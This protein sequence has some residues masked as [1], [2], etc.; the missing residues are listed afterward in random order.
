[1]ERLP[2]LL[3]AVAAFLVGTWAG[4]LFEDPVIGAIGGVAGLLSGAAAFGLQ[5][6]W[7]RR[8]WPRLAPVRSR[9]SRVWDEVSDIRTELRTAFKAGSVDRG[10]WE[11]RVREFDL[12]FWAQLR[13]IEPDDARRLQ[14]VEIAF[15]DENTNGGQ[16]AMA[17]AGRMLT[18]LE[19]RRDLVAE[20]MEFHRPG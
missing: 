19:K 14:T 1:M 2:T 5:T 16:A 9:L 10:A 12:H 13:R 18:L 8:R 15:E 7:A 17:W 4:G 3:A 11:P 6:A 20:R